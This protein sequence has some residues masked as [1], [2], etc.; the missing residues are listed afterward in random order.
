LSK[1]GAPAGAPVA[2][3]PLTNTVV[4]ALPPPWSASQGRPGHL[5]CPVFFAINGRRGGLQPARWNGIGA[6]IT[7]AHGFAP[8]GGGSIP[9]RSSLP[10]Y[11]PECGVRIRSSLRYVPIPCIGRGCS[12]FYNEVTVNAP[13]E[14]FGHVLH[15]GCIRKATVRR[16]RWVLCTAQSW[17]RPLIQT[18]RPPV[19]IWTLA[20]NNADVMRDY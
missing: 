12:I 6:A 19:G 18:S 13:Y 5:E 2:S 15:L 16:V 9:Q 4:L 7:C 14:S 11:R 1:P 17:R 10:T 20:I 8:V 3:K